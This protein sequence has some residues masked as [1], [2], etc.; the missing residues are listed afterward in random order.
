MLTIAVDGD[1]D[2]DDDD[3]M[4]EGLDGMTADSVGTSSSLSL[5]MSQ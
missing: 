2:G 4:D 5:I 3:V 1:G